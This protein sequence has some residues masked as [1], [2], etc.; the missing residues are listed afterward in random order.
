MLFVLTCGWQDRKH[1][2][3]DFWC[4]DKL[5]LISA[6]S[7]GEDTPTQFGSLPLSMT[8]LFLMEKMA[9][10]YKLVN[11]SY[12]WKKVEHMNDLFWMPL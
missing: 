3:W 9:Q 6:L 2:K 12:N 8:D 11:W 5:I 10:H 4:Y 1:V 7:A